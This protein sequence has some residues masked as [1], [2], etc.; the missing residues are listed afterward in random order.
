ML[1]SQDSKVT[2]KILQARFK[3]Y[4]SQKLTEVKAG[5]RKV[6]VTQGQI[7]NICW[8]MEK[9]KELQKNIYFCFIDYIKAFD[10]ESQQTVENS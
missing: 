10:C 9:A 8:I 4:V 2:L 7:A 5:F 1:I 6:R 3:Q